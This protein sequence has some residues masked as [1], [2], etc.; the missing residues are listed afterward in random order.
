[1]AT[2]DKVR[3]TRTERQT[4]ELRE[5]FRAHISNWWSQ[6][7]EEFRTKTLIFTL[8]MAPARYGPANCQTRKLCPP[9]RRSN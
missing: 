7:N 2:N 3:P 4:A 8:R 6:E 1:M 5:R 9:R